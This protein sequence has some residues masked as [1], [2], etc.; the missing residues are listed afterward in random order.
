MKLVACASS[1]QSRRKPLSN[2]SYIHFAS[3]CADGPFMSMLKEM[4]LAAID[5]E[6]RQLRWAEAE[7]L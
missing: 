6:I 4:G 3:P 2:T 1:Q 7:I 5:S